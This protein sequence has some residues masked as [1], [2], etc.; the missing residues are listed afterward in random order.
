MAMTDVAVE[1]TVVFGL[2][3]SYSSAA[4]DSDATMT[5]V[6]AAANFSDGEDALRRPL[7][8]FVHSFL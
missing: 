1:M 6:A 2:F 3:F 5:D 7:L 4:A 8:S